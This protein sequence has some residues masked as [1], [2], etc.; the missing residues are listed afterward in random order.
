MNNNFF[1]LAI[2]GSLGSSKEQMNDIVQ[3]TAS[4]LG[5]HRPIHLLGIGDPVDIWNFVR[6]GVDTFDCVNP[7]RIA[8]HGTALVRNKLD[9]INIKNSKYRDDF[10]KLDKLC[11]C[12][13]CINY[14]RSYLHHLF[15]IDEILGL[16]LLTSHNVHYMNSMMEF[17]R[18]A[19]NNDSLDQAQ[20]SWFLN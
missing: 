18:D 6:W 10:N 8:R 1:G 16:Q 5:T 15:K 12:N 17:I 11:N 19:I 7:T 14:S 4:K 13:T 2:G 9:K 20:N 3:Y